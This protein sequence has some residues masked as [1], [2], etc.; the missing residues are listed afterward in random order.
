MSNKEIFNFLKPFLLKEKKN[1]I[2]SIILAFISS[3]IG[4]AY[5]YLSGYAISAASSLAIKTAIITILLNLFLCFLNYII[6]NKQS[7]IISTRASFNIIK[8]ISFTLFDKVLKLPT[9]AFEE[10][11]SGEFINRITSDSETITDSINTLLNIVIKVITSILVFFY[12]LFNSWIVALEIVIYIFI[13][14]KISSKYKTK[15]KEFQKEIRKEND[16]YVANV[17]ESIHGIREIRALGIDNNITNGL[18]NIVQNLFNKRNSTIK[19]EQN[20]YSIIYVLDETFVAIVFITC[21][22]QILNGSGSLTFLVAMSYYIY[23]FMNLVNSF[24]SFSTYF[25]KLKVSVERINEITNNKLY[26][27]VLFGEYHNLNCKGKLEFKDVSF[28]YHD[29]KTNILNDFNLEIDPNKK[30][31]I[32]GKSGQGKSTI[33]NLLLR[34]F[35][36]TKGKILIDDIDIRDYDEESLRNNVSI[37]RQDPFLFNK[38]ILENFKMLNP[39]ITLNEVRKYCKKAL[40]DDYI[41][42]LPK[43]YNTMIGEGGINLSGGQKQRLAIARALSKNSKIILFDEATS[44]LDNE[45]QEKIIDVINEIS[46]DHTIITIAHRLSTIID[47]DVIHVMDNGKIVESGTHKELLKKSDIYKDLYKNN[48]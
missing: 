5:G 36:V 19:Y 48:I 15:L 42:S 9:K 39:K 25:Q 3:L 34:Y 23:N 16:F 21:I 22:I 8:D 46:K 27:D 12:V 24:A 17:N 41:M 47:S 45:S 40:I 29:Q 43:K 1:I 4:V 14:Y 7:I 11:S 33:F 37:I 32:I 26:Q 13:L 2:I 10:K 20:Y 6:F 35:D 38:T 18:R 31:A 30:I 44:A 28:R